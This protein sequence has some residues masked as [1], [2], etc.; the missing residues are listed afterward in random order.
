VSDVAVILDRRRKTYDLGSLR[1][2]LYHLA[3]SQLRFR[4]RGPRS[5]PDKRQHCKSFV[6]H[7]R[8]SAGFPAPP[9]LNMHTV[10]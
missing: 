2:P 4:S 6:F 1:P 10:R 8:A 7:A 9:L 5:D 3:W